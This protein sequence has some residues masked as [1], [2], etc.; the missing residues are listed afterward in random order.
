MACSYHPRVSRAGG[1]GGG[2]S[3]RTA[4]TSALLTCYPRTSRTSR[5]PPS[6]PVRHAPAILARFVVELALLYEPTHPPQTVPG[7]RG[8]SACRT[9]KQ[10]REPHRPR[11]RGEHHPTHHGQETREASPSPGRPLPIAHRR[12]QSFVLHSPGVAMT[13]SRYFSTTFSFPSVEEQDAQFAGS[14]PSAAYV[15]PS[16]LRSIENVCWPTRPPA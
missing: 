3:H 5:A 14:S 15:S 9:R 16:R 4:R 6:E 12:A 13:M 11:A 7:S 8:R 10:P 2:G 1:G